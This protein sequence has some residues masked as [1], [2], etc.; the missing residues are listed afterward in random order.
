VTKKAPTKKS[1]VEDDTTVAPDASQSNIKDD[2]EDEP[3]KPKDK[4][5][6]KDTQQSSR[7]ASPIAP[8][9]IDVTPI[10]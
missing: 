5:K 9:R 10:S 7:T 2:E 1:L 4:Q 6:L 3:V 8:K